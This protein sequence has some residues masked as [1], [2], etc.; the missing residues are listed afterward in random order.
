M[1]HWRGSEGESFPREEGNEFVVFLP[2][3]LRG[4]SFLV[5]DFFRGLLHHWGVQVHHLTPNSILHISIF[6]HLCEAFLGIEPHFDLFQY[7]FHLKPHPNESKID[8][9]GGAGLQF[10]QGKKPKYIPYELSDKVIDWM[11]MWFYARNLSS[12]LSLCT[13][14]PPVKKTSS[15]SRGGNAGQVNFLL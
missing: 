9:V 10:R 5:F 12:S 11:E 8:V 1:I 3:V 7:F 14:S 6:V 13:P 4:L 15:N 2:Y